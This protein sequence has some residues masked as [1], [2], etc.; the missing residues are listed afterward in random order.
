ML[1]PRIK[2][3]DSRPL[4]W[5]Q[6]SSVY[7]SVSPEAV[8]YILA[9]GIHTYY[10]HTHTATTLQK[11]GLASLCWFCDMRY[12]LVFPF[13]NSQSLSSWCFLTGRSP[14]KSGRPRTR[15][16]VLVTW[17]SGWQT[18]LTPRAPRTPPCSRLW[19]GDQFL[20]LCRNTRRP[21]SFLT[22]WCRHELNNVWSDWI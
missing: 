6:Q 19:W 16:T 2:N 1:Q 18:R 17:P 7:S 10:T 21:Q 11:V 14:L 4:Y 12:S 20:A 13:R 15:C 9:V 8:L 22:P 3:A 5:M